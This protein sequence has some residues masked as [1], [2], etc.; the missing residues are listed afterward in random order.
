MVDI[1]CIGHITSDKVVTAHTEMYMP[2]G[3]AYY[4]SCAVS[5]LNMSYVLVTSLAPAEMHYVND[6][7]S[8]GIDVK[9]QT[10]A[11]TVYFENI[12]GENQDERTQNVLQKADAFTMQEIQNVDAKVFHLGPLLADDIYRATCV[13]L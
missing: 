6:L 11:H 1:C 10:G 4:F 8:I 2:G 9:V 5:K 7:Q 13:K 12:Y 3:T